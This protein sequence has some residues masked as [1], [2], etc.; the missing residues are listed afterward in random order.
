LYPEANLGSAPSPWLAKKHEELG[1]LE[2]NEVLITMEIKLSVQAGPFLSFDL[3]PPVFV[4]KSINNVK[5]MRR[6]H[7]QFP[8]PN[9]WM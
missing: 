7:P 2:E 3:A 5:K 8:H 1:C 4:S 9:R 6:N